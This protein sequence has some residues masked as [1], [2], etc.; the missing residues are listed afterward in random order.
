M[1]DEIEIIPPSTDVEIVIGGVAQAGPPGADGAGSTNNVLYGAGAPSNGTGNN[2]NF[3][4]D[5]T[6]KDLYGPKAGGVWPA[7][8]SMI[9]PPGAD[10][11]D[12]DTGASGAPGADGRT[13]LS[14]TGAPSNGSG[15]NGDFY[16]DTASS[17]IYGPK[18][19]GSWPS[20][21][22]LVGPQGIQGVPG[23]PGADGADGS[24]G[25]AGADGRS[26]L[27]GS[28]APDGGTGANG[29]FYL[30]TTNYQLYGP[31]TAGAWGSPI[32]LAGADGTTLR[33]G[34]GAPSGGTGVN[35]EFY[36]NTS[37]WDIYGPKT[38]GAW[39]S[40]TSLLGATGPQGDPGADGKTIL[41]G[42]VAP[43]TEG[44]NGDF[45]IR[46]GSWLLYGPKAAGT[47]PTGVN[48]IGPQGDQ[49]I[50]GDTGADGADGA[51]GLT[52][53]NGAGA[54]SGGTG[55]NGDFYINTT[56]WNIHG[57]KAAGSWPSGVPLIG[58]NGTNGAD[59]ADGADGVDGVDGNTVLYGTAAPTTEGVDGDFYIR[60]TTNFIY[61][62]KAAGT[63]P[64]GTSLVGPTGSAGS[65]GTNGNTVLYGTAAPTTEGANGDFYIRTTT[66]YI[67]GPKASGTWPAG[68][69]LVGP[70]GGSFTSTT[71][72]TPASGELKPF[73][74]DRAAKL[75]PMLLGPD[76]EKWSL[77]QWMGLPYQTIRA[78]RAVS[79]GATPATVGAF[80]NS[81]T[82]TPG[83]HSMVAN[84]GIRGQTPKVTYTTAATNNAAAGTRHAISEYWRGTAAGEGGF[85]YGAR[86]GGRANFEDANN[87]TRAF[88]GMHGVNSV[89]SG[90]TEPSNLT[91]TIGMAKDG[92]DN[93]WFI[94]HNDSSGACTKIDLGSNFP[95]ETN[96]A[97]IYDVWFYCEGAGGNVEY[98]VERRDATTMVVSH[99]ASGTLSTDLPAT[100]TRL[101]PQ[102]WCCTGTGT[103]LAVGLDVY[104]QVIQLE[105]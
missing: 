70:S 97:D 6:A 29:D 30:N 105:Y 99:T 49:G 101:S 65:N 100:S 79:N 34:S 12:G 47:W 68:T 2:G 94:I 20:G 18:A 57:P 52:I 59:G 35:G 77:A 53:L 61:G 84:D 40:P 38:A 56:N 10:G 17:T 64:A 69:S 71:V 104:W 74:I 82:G 43:T 60:T 67:Y 36:I 48:L 72:P 92:T 98:Y 21:V 7:G 76:G 80:G 31:K 73:N 87:G 25:A 83:A 62:P 88:V 81:T 4:I 1:T 33:Y 96:Y 75:I 46:T 37:N 28:T 5:T 3:Y 41:S 66:N 89:I 26:L 16:Y 44:V 102:C 90:G 27:N 58:T 91:S 45:Y 85:L 14:G 13:I 39:G 42:S 8:T 9:G 24:P 32:D 93:N 63:W 54:P 55:V 15:Q 11:A 95:A 86:F 78:W 23:D 50:Q 103:P 19:A 51:N 22:S